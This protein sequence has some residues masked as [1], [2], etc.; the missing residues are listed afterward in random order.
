MTLQEALEQVEDHRSGPAQRYDLKEMIIMAICAVLCG[1]D[2]WV[3]VA[4]WCEEEEGWLRKF[5]VLANGTPSHDTFGKVFRVLDGTVFEQ[6]FRRW[7]A[8]HGQQS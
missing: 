4:D 2:S 7:V 8:E 1:A 5:L 3:D 6:C